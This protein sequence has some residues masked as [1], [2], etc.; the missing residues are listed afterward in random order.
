MYTQSNVIW[1]RLMSTNSKAKW[2][3]SSQSDDDESAFLNLNWKKRKVIAKQIVSA[4]EVGPNNFAL[5]AVN[6]CLEPEMNFEDFDTDTIQAIEKF[7]E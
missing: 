1:S 2:M 3:F 6:R 4:K 7:F 5:P